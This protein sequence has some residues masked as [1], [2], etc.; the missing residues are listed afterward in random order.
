MALLWKAQR[1]WMCCTFIRPVPGLRGGCHTLKVTG[2]YFSLVGC[3]ACWLLL[4][5][6]SGSSGSSGIVGNKVWSFGMLLCPVVQLID[7]FVK[8]IVQLSCKLSFTFLIDDDNHDSIELLMVV[9]SVSEGC[10]VF[11]VVVAIL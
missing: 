5:C 3:H 7:W 2:Y 10:K 8:F 9:A 6:K 4:D 11:F 1:L